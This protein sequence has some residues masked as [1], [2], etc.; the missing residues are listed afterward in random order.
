MAVI[1]KSEKEIDQIKEKILP[2]LKKYSATRAGIFGSYV[3]GNFSVNSDIDI[4][5][6]LKKKENFSLL[7]YIG[8]QQELEKTLGKKVDLV[9][10]HTLKPYIKDEVLASE[11]QI[12]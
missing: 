12:L 9:Q 8:I 5:V 3:K 7:D 6:Q 11:V 2:I 1:T 10:Y 4:L